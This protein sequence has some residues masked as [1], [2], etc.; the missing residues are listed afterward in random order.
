MRFMGGNFNHKN[1][2]R[3]KS[4]TFCRSGHILT[5]RQR[6]A[7]TEMAQDK[8]NVLLTEV[9][10]EGYCFICE[11]DKLFLF[12]SNIEIEVFILITSSFDNIKQLKLWTY[13]LFSIKKKIYVKENVTRTKLIYTFKIPKNF[14]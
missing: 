1:G 10:L 8:D 2:G 12:Q 9:S 11:T 14:V 4:L 13:D 5:T 7:C 3:G 6:I